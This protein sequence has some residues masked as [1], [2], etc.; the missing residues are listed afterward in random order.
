MTAAVSGVDES[1]KQVVRFSG[2]HRYFAEAS[3][4]SAT[5]GLLSS[6]VQLVSMAALL[7]AI[8]C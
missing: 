2:A 3:A 4:I 7:G 1:A 5:V 8:S 6:A